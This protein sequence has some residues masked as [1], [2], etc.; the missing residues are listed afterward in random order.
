ME[1]QFL[2]VEF[3]AGEGMLA[4]RRG[5]PRPPRHRHRLRRTLLWATSLFALLSL[6]GYALMVRHV[7]PGSA[8]SAMMAELANVPMY[9]GEQVEASVA[10]YR[11]SPWDYFRSTHGVL[12]ATS[13]RLLL[14]TIPPAD[15]F[16]GDVERAVVERRDFPSDTLMG[17][18]TGR[19]ILGVVRGVALRRGHIRL[20]LAVQDEEWAG[21]R[22]VMRI[23]T[24]RRDSIF[25]VAQTARRMRTLSDQVARQPVWYRVRTGDALTTIAATFNT[26]PERLREIN[27]LSDDRIRVGDSILVKPGG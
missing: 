3:S 17:L 1:Q 14:L 9:P 11:R 23:V 19:V 21:L 6:V 27:R 7:D 8:R 13:Y 26:T 4:P 20:T 2:D 24:T 15:R 25:A 12:A 5:L 18:D 10:V 16:S 22:A